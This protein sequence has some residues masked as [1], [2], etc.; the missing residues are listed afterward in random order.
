MSGSPMGSAHNS[1]TENDPKTPG[2]NMINLILILNKSYLFLIDTPMY[3]THSP[4]L[5][6]RMAHKIQHKFVFEIVSYCARTYA[7]A[8]FFLI[9]I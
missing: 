1:D 2:S 6:H 8:Y 7:F 9:H 5:R 3:N 4:I